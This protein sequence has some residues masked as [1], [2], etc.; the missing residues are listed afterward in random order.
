MTTARSPVAYSGEPGAFAEDAVVAA[1]GEAVERRPVGGFREVFDAVAAG[2]VGAGVVPVENLVN[3]SVRETY[4]LLL[5][6]DHEIGAEVVVP[7]ELCLAAPSGRSIDD[8]RRVYSHIQALGQAEGFLRGRPWSLLT[9]Y[10]T[11]GA[12]KM[13][14]ESGEDGAAAVLSPRAAHRYGLDVLAASIQDVPDNRTRF[15][16]IRTRG[17]ATADAAGEAAVG[18]VTGRATGEAVGTVAADRA[19]PVTDRTRYRTTLA[20]GVHNEPGTLLRALQ[21]FADRSINLS[22][23]ESRPSRN[24]AWEYVFWTDLDAN[25]DDA[26]CAAALTELRAVAT[27]VR[28]FGSYPRVA[29]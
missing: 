17:E 6:F 10:N 24:A 23:L 13:V 9:T 5:E 8:V 25:A 19:N 26:D 18:E 3:G 14:A 2:D 11:A 29:A 21:V 20:F 22:K 27:L 7:V 28:T 16:V 4:D 15:V 1:F 12:G